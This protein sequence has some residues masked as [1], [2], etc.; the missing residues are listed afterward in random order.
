MAL[1]APDRHLT[2]REGQE[3]ISAP[4][5][6][7]QLT[8]L[9]HLAHNRPCKECAAGRVLF[10]VAF[11]KV[12]GVNHMAQKFGSSVSSSSA[13]RNSAI[14]KSEPQQRGNVTREMIAKRAYEIWKSGKGG[15][16]KDN[17][18][19]AERELRSS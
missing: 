7:L 3:R 1:Y 19:R 15:N 18:L 12:Q 9:H 10:Q 2:S 11:V 16:E 17:W 6:L 13:V 5:S 8:R 14:P 4:T